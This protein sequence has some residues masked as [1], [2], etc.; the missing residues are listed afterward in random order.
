[1]A[2]ELDALQQRLAEGPSLDAIARGVSAI[3]ASDLTDPS[4]WPAW[5]PAA[6]QAGVRS[7]LVK[8]MRTD[9]RTEAL[10]CYGVYPDAFGMADRARAQVLA[11]LA[12]LALAT[13][14]GRQAAEAR[15]GNLEAGM[16]TRELIGQAQGILMERGTHRR[17]SGLRH[18]A[19]GVPAS[20]SQ[21]A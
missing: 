15:A 5:A 7:A 13:A 8:A 1:M 18:P 19:P 16:A 14:E 17:G 4:P 10:N 20:Q 12:G 9:G 21:A 2:A 3:Y 11:T 6:V